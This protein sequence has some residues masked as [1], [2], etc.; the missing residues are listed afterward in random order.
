MNKWVQ[1]E[2]EKQKIIAMNLSASEYEKAVK[3]L[4][5]KLKI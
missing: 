3:K 2:I 5:N 1:Y 4:V